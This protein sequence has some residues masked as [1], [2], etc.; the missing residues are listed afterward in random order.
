MPASRF[1]FTVDRRG[2]QAA[3]TL[4]CGMGVYRCRLMPLEMLERLIE[5]C[6]E[7]RSETIPSCRQDRRF[8]RRV[9]AYPDT[10]AVAT[11]GIAG[12]CD[13]R[14]VASSDEVSGRIEF[15]TAFYDEEDHSAPA[16]VLVDEQLDE[17]IER[18]SCVL[19]D[20]ES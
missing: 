12:A 9:P 17:F 20:T 10:V 16:L 5:L 4:D 19:L 7:I 2:D 1:S 15:C 11:A 13:I 14:L 8:L 18:A 6:H 3:V